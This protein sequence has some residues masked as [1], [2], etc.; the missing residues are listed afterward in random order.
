MLAA[1]LYPHFPWRAVSNVEHNCSHNK[2][3]SESDY[4]SE[5]KLNTVQYENKLTSKTVFAA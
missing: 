3:E 1:L 2:W 4:Q 5:N